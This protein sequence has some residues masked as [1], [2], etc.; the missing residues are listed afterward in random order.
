MESS[1]SIGLAGQPV[2]ATTT[3]LKVVICPLCSSE[4]GLALFTQRNYTLMRCKV[5]DLSYVHPYP[6][7]IKRHHETVSDY[8]YADLEV[9]RCA[10]Q[11]ANEKLFYTRYFDLIDRE[12]E[13]ATSILDVGCGCGHLLERLSA[14][15]GLHRA[16][17][18]LNHER[19]KFARKTAQCEI[20]KTPIE[21]F[22]VPNRF[23]VIALINVFSH[24][25]DIGQL[26]GKLRSCLAERGKVILKTG[27]I[28]PEVK[29][30][31]IFDW[32]FPDHLHFL[33][34]RT[35]DYSSANHRFQIQK[36]LRTRLSS[37]RFA[38]STWRMKGRSGIRNAIKG[39]VARV[40]F[41]LPFLAGCCDAVHRSSISSSFIVLRAE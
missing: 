17:I 24:I 28:K 38:S 32:E 30:S 4:D 27:E 14:R 39:A 31:A 22:N 2:P 5:C 23:D 29:K 10:T 19:A 21:D 33:G 35:I 6:R 16:G 34:W 7:D 11:Y 18:E 26:F 3:D 9:V 37:E 20:F 15:R 25:P 12:C 41:A 1:A 40:P 36:H 13:A 8:G